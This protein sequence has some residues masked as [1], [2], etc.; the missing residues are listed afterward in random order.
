M[1]AQSANRSE[2]PGQAKNEA[3]HRAR[4]ECSHDALRT[5]EV[6]SALWMERRGHYPGHIRALLSNSYWESKMDQ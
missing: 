6:P 1:D 2:T 3:E 4:L 5:K